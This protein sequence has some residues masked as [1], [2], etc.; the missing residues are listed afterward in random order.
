MRLIGIIDWMGLIA[1]SLMRF[2]KYL[3][4]GIDW[5]QS[6]RTNL[7]GRWGDFDLESSIE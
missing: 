5:K 3:Q 2:W 4:N 6:I 7:Q 1:E